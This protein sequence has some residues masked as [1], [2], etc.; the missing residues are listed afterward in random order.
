[1]S[2]EAPV[3]EIHRDENGDVFV[4]VGGVKIAKRGCPA[5][6][7]PTRG[8]CS[9]R[10]GWSATLKA[11]RQSKSATSTFECTNPLLGNGGVEAHD[12]SRALPDLNN[13]AAVEKLFGRFDGRRIIAMLNNYSGFRSYGSI[14]C[15]FV[16]MGAFP[17][18]E[19]MQE[20]T[21]GA[22]EAGDGACGKLAQVRLERASA[23]GHHVP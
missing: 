9:N 19:D 14:A 1:M 20:R 13:I 7:M 10:D 16:I 21:D 6:R 22:V 3:C 11:G 18:L 17:L 2:D 5:R 4:L 8:L 15:M 23:G 12:Q